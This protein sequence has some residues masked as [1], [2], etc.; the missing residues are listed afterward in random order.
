MTP[1]QRAHRIVAEQVRLAHSNAHGQLDNLGPPRYV[2]ETRDHLA[3]TYNM[4][5]EEFEL[6]AQPLPMSKEEQ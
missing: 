6:D 2:R 5:I 4:I 3:A 1:Q